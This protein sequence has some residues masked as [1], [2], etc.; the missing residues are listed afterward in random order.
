MFHTAL[1]YPFV[2]R[3]VRLSSRV[4]LFMLLCITALSISL[5]T[6]LQSVVPTLVVGQTGEVEYMLPP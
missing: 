5:T 2:T 3:A 4:N 6:A 1:I